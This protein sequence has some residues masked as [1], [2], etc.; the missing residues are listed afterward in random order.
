VESRELAALIESGKDKVISMDGLRVQQF[1][2]GVLNVKE[3]DETL[4]RARLDEFRA[5][6]TE[7]GY[8]EHESW[9]AGQGASWLGPTMFAGVSMRIRKVR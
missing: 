5:A 3:P 6:L 7:A 1:N 9:V 8:R 2:N 4:T